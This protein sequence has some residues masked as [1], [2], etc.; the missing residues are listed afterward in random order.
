M[1]EET[2]LVT[3]QLVLSNDVGDGELPNDERLNA[4]LQTRLMNLIFTDQVVHT[5][6]ARV[7]D[8]SGDLEPPQPGEIEDILTGETSTC[9][10]CAHRIVA[11][12]D[13]FSHTVDWGADGDFGCD[14][15]PETDEEGCGSHNP[16]EGHT[17][18]GFKIPAPIRQ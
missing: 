10:W 15:N 3:V 2:A 7:I 12:I 4:V 8:R 1:S 9:H 11:V 18:V 6:S 17:P 5:L 16:G 13:P 14:R